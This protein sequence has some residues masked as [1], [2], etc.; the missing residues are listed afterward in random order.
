MLSGLA[1]ILYGRGR[2]FC[3]CRILSMVALYYF[4]WRGRTA[5]TTAGLRH[6]RR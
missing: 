6:G 4:R 1:D 3:V 2:R 5:T